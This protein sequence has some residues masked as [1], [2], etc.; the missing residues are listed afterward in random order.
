M[1]IKKISVYIIPIFFFFSYSIVYSDSHIT[2]PYKINGTEFD[3]SIEFYKHPF[4]LG[5][6]F[7]DIKIFNLKNNKYFE[8]EA[9]FYF[10]TP[11][12]QKRYQVYAL[13]LPGSDS[14]YKAAYTFKK[15]GIWLVELELEENTQYEKI[16]FEMNIEEAS[17][18]SY[19]YGYL[20]MLSL[21]LLI[22]VGVIILSKEARKNKK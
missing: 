17:V 22:L 3:V 9:K 15:S 7:F 13:K 11:D 6:Q 19:K 14:I 2:N 12:K 18:G 21:P 16:F 8:G 5:E 1:L 20:L 4:K 10:N